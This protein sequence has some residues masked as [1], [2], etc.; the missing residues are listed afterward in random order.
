MNS[1][2]S[3]TP[4][5]EGGGEGA[6]AVPSRAHH[7][8]DGGDLVL[9][10]HDG[11]AVLAGVRIDTELA[12]VAL[13]GFGHRGRRRDRVPGGDGRAAVHAAEGGRAVAVDEDALA[14]AVRP[15]DADAQRPLQVL[16]RELASQLQRLHVGSEQLLLALVLL[17]EQLLDFRRVD[18][19][20]HGQR[21]DVDDVLEQLPLAR[22]GIDRVA[23]LGERHADH[24]H[25]RAQAAGG[26]GRVLS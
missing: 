22:I 24:V 8:A 3:E 10:L 20:Q 16:L 17:A 23:D 1:V 14:H 13:E 25:V 12:A 2:I 4:G 11:I 18:L 15:P 5:P 19:Q 6:R 9:R 26:T 7:H 21:A